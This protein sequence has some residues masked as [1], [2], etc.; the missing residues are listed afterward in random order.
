MKIIISPAKKMNIHT[1]LFDNQ[2]L[3]VLI[4]ESDYL[5]RRIQA[6][7][8]GEAKALW[9]C[10]DKLA[11]LNYERFRAMDTRASL[12]PALLSYQGLQYQHIAPLVLET[13][14]WDYIQNRLRILSGFYGIIRPL[15]GVTPYRLEMQAGLST[16]HGRNLY[17]FWGRKLHDELVKDTDIIINLASKEYSRTIAPYI[18]SSHVFITCVFGEYRGGKVIEKGTIAKMARGEMVRY[19]AEQN[20]AAPEQMKSFDRIGFSFEE[21]LSSESTYVFLNTGKKTC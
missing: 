14:Q 18:E 13:K 21:Q 17:E 5:T 10:N 7:S 1:D 4:E 19:M 8:Y 2:G 15:D 3:P 6:L 16:R 11:Q 12:T 20:I 9:R